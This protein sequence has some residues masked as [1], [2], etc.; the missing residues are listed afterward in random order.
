MASA[1]QDA[2]SKS[3]QAPVRWLSA[4]FRADI[5]EARKDD[6][7]PRGCLS[8]RT[9]APPPFDGLPLVAF[10]HWPCR[11]H[12]MRQQCRYYEKLPCDFRH[13]L[14]FRHMAVARISNSLRPSPTA[15][16]G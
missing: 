8:N 9:N 10:G 3:L 1:Q 4:N 6:S 16:L 14:I 2:K 5:D 15:L 12:S 11:K 7:K 13:A